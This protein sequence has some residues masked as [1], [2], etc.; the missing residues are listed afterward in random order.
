MK[1]LIC[2]AFFLFCFLSSAQNFVLTKEGLKDANIKENNYLVLKLDHKSASESYQIALKFVEN[3]YLNPNTTI[4]N[5]SENSHLVFNTKVK[6]FTDITNSGSNIPVGANYIT[7][8]RFKDNKIK[9]TIL[10][11]KIGNGAYNVLWKGSVFEGYVIWN[12]KDV[13]IRN[14]TKL[15][16][17]DFF[18]TKANKLKDYIL[19]YKDEDDW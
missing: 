2:T 17:E 5:N 7:E 16:I 15:F 13:L 6:K 3:K 11:L 9:F 18:T 12:E 1:N 4:K 14:E 19:N 10:D 8:I